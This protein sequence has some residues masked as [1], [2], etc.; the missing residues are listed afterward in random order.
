MSVGCWWLGGNVH[1]HLERWA[2]KVTKLKR[3]RG[4]KPLNFRSEL[5][6][7][8]LA[9]SRVRYAVTGYEAPFFLEFTSKFGASANFYANA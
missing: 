3:M 4:F 7:E 2:R 6:R 9:L 8:I 5:P 1:N